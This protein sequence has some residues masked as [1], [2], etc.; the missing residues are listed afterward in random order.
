MLVS[1]ITTLCLCAGS[2]SLA[3]GGVY[4]AALALLVVLI[5]AALFTIRGYT[6]TGDVLQVHR[7]FWDTHLPLVEL[8]AAEVDPNAMKKSWRTAGN[9]GLYSF[10]GYFHNEALGD[11]RALVTDPALSVVLRFRTETVVVSP[12]S[13]GAFARM[14]LSQTP[15]PP[16]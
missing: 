10:S 6:I 8:Q 3:L 16:C 1:W 15:A 7:L 12:E 2:I 5:A 14:I 4:F 9:G 11:F 13:P